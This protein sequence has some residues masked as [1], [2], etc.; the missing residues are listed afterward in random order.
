MRIG[1][2]SLLCVMIMA[3]VSV[4]VAKSDLKKHKKT[5]ESSLKKLTAQYEADIDDLGKSYSKSLMKLVTAVATKSADLDKSKRIVREDERFEAKKNVPE[6]ALCKD[7]PELLAMQEAYRKGRVR[8]ELGYADKHLILAGRY[9]N[10]LKSI[11]EHH[12]KEMQF[13]EA[14]VVQN[15]RKHLLETEAYKKSRATIDGHLTSIKEQKSKVVAKPVPMKKAP[16][17]KEEEEDPLPKDSLNHVIFGKKKFDEVKWLGMER[18]KAVKILGDH[19][20]VISGSEAGYQ[21]HNYH[22]QHGFEVVFFRN[23][24]VQYHM[25]KNYRAKT[26]FGIKAGSSLRDITKKYGDIEREEISKIYFTGDEPKV[27]YH[28]KEYNKYKIKYPDH[29]VLFWLDGN[30][31]VTSVTVAE[32]HSR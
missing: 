12:T 19:P 30:K 25:W 5:Y 24:T 8:R 21:T 13:D 29:S 27:L 16:V 15:E 18:E 31:V 7:V 2:V 26:V 28:H 6:S 20:D 11:Q 1:R 9:D 4:A 23:R 17:V 22:N 3:T 14:T 32:R 10:A